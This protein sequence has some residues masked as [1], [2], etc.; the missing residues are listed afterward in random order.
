MQ[1]HL[2]TIFFKPDE[3]IKWICV[4]DP[5]TNYIN[6]IYLTIKYDDIRIYN[7]KDFIWLKDEL[8]LNDWIQLPCPNNYKFP[9]NIRR[10]LKG[11]NRRKIYKMTKA[12]KIFLENYIIV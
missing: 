9:C 8:L 5:I 1:R 2:P 7:F 4:Y 6:S 11:K 3:D 10:I 12:H